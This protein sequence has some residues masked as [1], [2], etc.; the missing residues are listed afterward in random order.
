MIAKF[1]PGNKILVIDFDHTLYDT[2][3]F[4][5]FEIRRVMLDE[6]HIPTKEW[7][8][9]YELAVKAGYTIIRHFEELAKI[10]PEYSNF[11]KEK[12]KDFVEKINF[13]KYLYEDT[14][15]FL[16]EAKNKGYKIVLISFGAPNWQDKKVLGVGFDKIMDVIRYTKEEGNKLEVLK[17][18]TQGCSK[19][20]FVE[21]NGQDLDAV[22]E[23]LPFV[24]THLMNRVP[25]EA[26]NAEEDEFM[27]IRYSESRRIA[28][29]QVAF[30][31]KRVHTLGEVIL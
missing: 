5:L 17:Q 3:A 13:S 4:L 27:R 1:E 21:N 6:F 2:D 11:S 24:E 25:D 9:S 29:K 31:H 16:N 26:M 8:D 22:H 18:Y 19:V 20:V 28:K 15:S 12:I 7:E 10:L 14:M 23:V 30:D